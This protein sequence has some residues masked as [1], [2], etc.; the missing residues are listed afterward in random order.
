M[1]F[2]LTFLL[3]GAVLLN[4]LPA[5]AD[6]ISPASTHE[7]D[8]NQLSANTTAHSGLELKSPLNEGIRAEFTPPG[9]G[10]HQSELNNPFNISDSRSSNAF[11]ALFFAREKRDIH[12]VN[13]MQLDS[14]RGGSSTSRGEGD[15]QGDSDGESDGGKDKV[16]VNS[17]LAVVPEPESLSLLLL[18]LAA[19]GS[20]ARRRR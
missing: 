20:L 1:K 9:R 6:G 3:C 5:W 11:D 8:G 13:F 19:I 14:H 15:G 16:K 18:G 2:R 4:S 7:F 12:P 17:N 10:I